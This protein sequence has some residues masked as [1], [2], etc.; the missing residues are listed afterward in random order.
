M[1]FLQQVCQ[2][3]ILHT[4]LL[5]KFLNLLICKINLLLIFLLILLYLPK[6]II[7]IIFFI[8]TAI[9]D[10]HPTS[11]RR[12]A[13]CHPFSLFDLHFRIYINVIGFD[14]IA[15]LS[16][17]VYVLIILLDE[18]RIH[19]CDIIYVRNIGIIIICL[20]ELIVLMNLIVLR[21]TSIFMIVYFLNE[22]VL[23]LTHWLGHLKWRSFRR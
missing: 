3:N 5:F 6:V 7:V 22:F 11:W 15:H 4:N 19:H 20:N 8:A 18:F 17:E 21:I 1:Q 23:R 10:D 16:W 9:S 14:F 12:Y 13:F 2:L